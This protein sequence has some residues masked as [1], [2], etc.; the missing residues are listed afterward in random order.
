MS[1]RLAGAVPHIAALLVIAALAFA[2]YQWAQVQQ[3]QLE[4]AALATEFG[5]YRETLERQTR[6]LVQLEAQKGARIAK[7]RQE[8]LDAE[9]LARQA[10]QA[11]ADR[12]RGSAGQLQRYA[13]DLATSLADRA[14]DAAAASRCTAAEGRIRQLSE[15]VGALD[16]FAEQA[17][18]A[19]EVRGRA[20]LLCER[21]FDA[22]TPEP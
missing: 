1:E 11:D 7:T 13:E 4:K 6:E 18:T 22:L 15:L 5:V 16:D 12:L 21:T 2:G 17:A 10:A 8:A 3:Q 14:R 20:G 9:L 19:A